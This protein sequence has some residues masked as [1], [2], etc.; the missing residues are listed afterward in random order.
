MVHPRA[1]AE[2]DVKEMF[3]LFSTAFRADQ[4]GFKSDLLEKQRVLRVRGEEG[5]VAFSTLT[6]YSPEPGVRVVFSGDTY[7]SPEARVG[8]GLPGLWA[9]YVFAEM[10]REEGLDYY[11]LLLCSGYRTYRLLP[12]FFLHY[13]PEPESHP[14]LCA[15]LNTWAKE[16]FGDSF[17]RGVVRPRFATPLKDPDPPERL[18]SDPHVA[19]FMNS[20]P[21]YSQG[22][23]LV[24]L[25]SLQRENLTPAGL[26]LAR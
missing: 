10:P 16:I 26:R 14:T 8:E 19:Y 9:R 23:E 13:A 5:L 4:G 17:E 1:L 7:V 25:T 21:G 18:K 3:S 2:D 12:T 15:K 6:F 24:C 11:W 20:N 22:D